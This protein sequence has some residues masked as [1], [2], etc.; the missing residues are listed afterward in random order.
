MRSVCFAQMTFLRSLKAYGGRLHAD[1]ADVGEYIA[2][3]PGRLEAREAILL[4]VTDAGGGAFLGT[5]MLFGIDPVERDAELGFW[6]SSR[7]RGRGLAARAIG[8]TVRW[9][10]AELGLER[11]NGLTETDNGAAQRA[12]ENAGLVREGVLRGLEGRSTGRVDFVSYSVLQTDEPS[13]REV[14]GHQS[15]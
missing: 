1:P 6:L 5:T 2:R 9:A 10:F 3:V 12:M 13:W 14:R 11:V 4:A 7:A 15:A 8:L